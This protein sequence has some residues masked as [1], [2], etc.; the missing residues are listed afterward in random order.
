MGSQRHRAK[1][2]LTNEEEED[3]FNQEDVPLLEG[4]GEDCEC[5]NHRSDDDGENGE[6]RDNLCGTPIVLCKE[7]KFLI[8][9]QFE[10]SSDELCMYSHNIL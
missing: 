2:I 4:E 1:E 6:N 9:N 5:V 7:M 10:K 3:D 8:V